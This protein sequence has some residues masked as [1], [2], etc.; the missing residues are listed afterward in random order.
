MNNTNEPTFATV[1]GEHWDNLPSVIHKHYANRPYSEDVVI[2]EGKLDVSCS[3]PVKY[4]RPLFKLLGS[5]PP[6]NQKAVPVTVRFESCKVSK[7]F[8]FNRTFHFHGEKPYSF[9]SRMLQ[10]QGNELV[11][12]MSFNIGWR[13]N[14]LWQD[15]KVILKHKGYVLKIFGHLIPLP[16]SFL[17]GEGYAEEIPVDDDH[18][19]MFVNMKHPLFGKIYEYRGRFKVTEMNIAEQA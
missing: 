17:L 15:K 9:R 14:Y 10:I 11:E 18:F 5:V 1:F 2:A 12:M 3:G 4:L 13:F 19:D 6:Y 8:R 16:I 7:E